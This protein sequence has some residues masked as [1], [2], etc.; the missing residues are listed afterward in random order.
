MPTVL[1]VDDE[2]SILE[3]LEDVLLDAGFVVVTAMNGREGLERLNETMPDL[4]LLDLM[5][6]VMDGPGMLRGMATNPAY[7]DIPVVMMSSLP[8]ESVAAA[9]DGFAAFLRK[10]F[11]IEVLVQT[12]RRVLDGTG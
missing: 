2:I 12:I 4:V 7:R 1:I 8:R 6:P 5:M 10:P 9:S 3:V 11:R